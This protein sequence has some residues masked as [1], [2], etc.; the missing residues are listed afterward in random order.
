MNLDPIVILAVRLLEVRDVCVEHLGD[1]DIALAE[2]EGL[3]ECLKPCVVVR[4]ARCR[5]SGGRPFARSVGIAREADIR[6]RAGIVVLIQNLAGR[7]GEHHA[8]RIGGK[9]ERGF[10]LIGTL[11]RLS[12][13]AVDQQHAVC[14]NLRSRGQRILQRL[15]RRIG[16]AVSAEINLRA[17]GVVKLDPVAVRAVR[18]D[19]R[20]SIA[21]HKFVDE[22][23]DRLIRG[24]GQRREIF[25]RALVRVRVAGAG[26]HLFPNRGVIRAAPERI[27]AGH[28]LELD[29]VHH[30]AGGIGEDHVVRSGELK[31]CVHFSARGVPAAE[32]NK[33]PAG[34]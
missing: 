26:L 1:D 24:G 10:D 29:A 34:R 19:Q 31:G 21:G 6:A 17:G 2:R 9:P 20:R 16:D 18:A 22:N 15:G 4:I 14:G 11:R 28:G 32:Y 23:A 25:L 5:L 30:L 13:G 12:A 8:L 7:R 3:H 33:I 27:A